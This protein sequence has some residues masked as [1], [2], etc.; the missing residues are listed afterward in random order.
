VLHLA[1]AT[2]SFRRYSTY[3]AATIAGVFTN[4]VFGL[5]YSYAYLAL[6]EENPAAGGYDAT[7]AVTYVWLGQALLMTIALWG[8][9]STD[10][11]A[12]R[13]RTG[14]VA[15]DLYRPVGIVGWYLAADLGRAAYHFLTR[16][17]GPTVIG[18]LLFEIALPSGP[19]A[20]AA[21]AVSLVLAVVVSFGVR[22]LVATTAFWLLDQSGVRVM[23][24]AFALFFSGM[25]LP[26]VLFPGWLGTLAAALPWSAYL[27]VPAD[28]WLGKRTGADLVAALGFQVFWALVLLGFCQAALRAATRKVVVQGG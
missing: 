16:G 21:F 25:M 14:D 19:V 13:I 15:I 8:G 27:Q 22:F 24:G 10:D 12:E 17:I 4:S 18:F 1:V 9:G 2:R 28:I 20:A 7:D 6:W 11:L 3:R 23:S 5:I 26:L